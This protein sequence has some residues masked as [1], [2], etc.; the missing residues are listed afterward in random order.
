MKKAISALVIVMTVSLICGINSYAQKKFK[1]IVNYT[2]AYSGTIDPA[3]AA[4]QPKAMILSIYENK[5]KMNIPMG[6][7]N[8]DIITDG[9]AKT[10]TTLLDIMGEKKYYKMTTEEI[11]KQISENPEPVI[12]YKEET[13]TVAGYTCKK[14]EYSETKDD[15]KSTTIVYYTEDL[16]GEL[17][18]YGGQF[19]KL[20]GV[21]LEY[22]ITTPDGIITTFTATEVKK[23][24]VKDTDFLIPDD[25]VELTAEE[26]QQM[27][28]QMKGEE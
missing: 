18:N 26:K 21:P 17:L 1:G 27:M 14:A 24:K 7:V 5:Q 25:Y 28:N 23:G 8:I 12:T 15:E 16:G 19:N 13:K 6:P 2:I 22:V 20:K 4:Q 11:E 10:S 3:T 9:D